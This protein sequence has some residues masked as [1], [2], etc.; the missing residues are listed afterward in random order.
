MCPSCWGSA[1]SC[2]GFSDRIT[3]GAMARCST[4][5]HARLPLGAL[6]YI[7]LSGLH[8][9]LIHWLSR[10]CSVTWLSQGSP[11]MPVFTLG[12]WGA[13]QALGWALLPRNWLVTRARTWAG[14]LASCTGRI[15]L[16]A[17]FAD[18]RTSRHLTTPRPGR[19]ITS[20]CCHSRSVTQ[21]LA[22]PSVRDLTS[23][24][25]PSPRTR[26]PEDLAMVAGCT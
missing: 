8:P 7:T 4:A 9:L 15:P 26:H 18:T 13:R 14:H 2:S 17:L 1:C 10:S 22:L 24:L 3:L 16:S 19:F 11:V 25:H 21:C 5:Q 20:A 12:H 6:L 23:S